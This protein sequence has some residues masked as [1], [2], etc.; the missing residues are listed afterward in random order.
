MRIYITSIPIADYDKALAFYTEILGFQKKRDIELGGGARFLTVV[1]PEDPDGTE[2][3]LEPN[4]DYRGIKA[5]RKALAE[6][7]IPITSLAVDDVQAEY[8]RLQKLGVTF[9]QKPFSHGGP[10]TAVFDDTNG[11][12]IQ[13]VEL[14]KGE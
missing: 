11:N 1:S 4:A 9:T 12:L 2:I 13:I 3:L 6:D 5:L 10:T 7:G 14:K 8:E